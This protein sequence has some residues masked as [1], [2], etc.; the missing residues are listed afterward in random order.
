MS[1]SPDG[2]DLGSHDGVINRSGIAHGSEN[3]GLTKSGGLEFVEE[4][5]AFFGARD[6]GKPIGLVGPILIREPLP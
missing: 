4:G 6:S 3:G 1:D 2:A 5:H